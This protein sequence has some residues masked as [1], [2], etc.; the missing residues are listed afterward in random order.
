MESKIREVLID[1]SIIIDHL[2]SKEKDITILY[3]LNLNFNL[4]IS[5]ITSFELYCGAIDNSRKMND[6]KLIFGNFKIFELNDNISRKSAEIYIKLKSKG[7]SVDTND[8]FI[9]ATALDNNYYLSTLNTKH[10]KDID[11]LH[12]INNKEIF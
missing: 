5:I 11:N 10:F 1:T 9:A 4:G 7:I 2:K 3:K 12:L 8:I 6:L